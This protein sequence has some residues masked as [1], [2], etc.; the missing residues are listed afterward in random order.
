MDVTIASF[1][2][3]VVA[4]LANIKRPVGGWIS[5]L[6]GGFFS[7]RFVSFRRFLCEVELSTNYLRHHQIIY[8]K[9]K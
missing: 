7:F 9:T 2:G 5:P 3:I 8:L 1:I 6:M 4:I